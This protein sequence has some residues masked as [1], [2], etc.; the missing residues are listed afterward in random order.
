M[1]YLIN[2]QQIIFF[3][4]MIARSPIILNIFEDINILIFL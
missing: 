3:N 1:L 2:L 4:V